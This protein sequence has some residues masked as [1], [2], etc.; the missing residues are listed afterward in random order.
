VPF[1]LFFL[2]AFLEDVSLATLDHV[3]PEAFF[4][5]RHM[6][7]SQISTGQFDSTKFKDSAE[8][9]SVDTKSQPA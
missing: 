4:P 6:P 3:I 7:F 1:A 2:G 5:R 8:E 9:A